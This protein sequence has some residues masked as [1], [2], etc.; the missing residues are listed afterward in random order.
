VSTLGA[1][2]RPPGPSDASDVPSPHRPQG[3]VDRA[4]RA[5]WA[6]VVGLGAWA[7]L[8]V[9]TRVWGLAVVW[10]APKPLYV[11]AVPFFGV[12]EAVPLPSL[13]PAA[14]ALVATVVLAPILSRR[15]GWRGLLV[16]VAVGAVVVSLALALVEPAA[17]RWGNIEGDYGQFA[18]LVDE[19][20]P[21]GFLR[22]YT[23]E[24]VGYPTHLSAHPPGMVLLMWAEQQ[25][26][27]GGTA[28]QIATVMAAVAMAAVS[29]LVALRAL[30]GEAFARAA[31]PFLVVA[32]AAVWHINAD[33]V[34]GGIALAGVALV[35]V[36]TSRDGRAAQCRALGGGALLGAALL[37]SQGMVLMAVPALAVLAYRRRVQLAAMVAVSG[38]VVVLLPLLWGFWWLDSLSATKEAYDLNLAQ[39]RPYGFFLVANLAAFAVAVGPAI[40]VALA[41]L[42]DR[43]VWVLVGGGLAAVALA[44]LSGLSLAE[45]ERIWQPFMPLVLAAGGALALGRRDGGRGWLWLQAGTTLA[46]VYALRSPW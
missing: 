28:A 21:G 27:L 6:A 32:P 26:G 36:A 38:A 9:V 19:K 20:G 33:V 14:V 7:A 15:M 34:F 39:V 37:F 24:Q 43:A 2:R 16:A 23:D 17:G 29:V 18:S 30:A 31:A 25:V 41:G 12:W 35:A 40:A 1:L 11:D 44:D 8:V 42:R 45:T 3:A 46:L 10:G 13:V 22:D 5:R 4:D